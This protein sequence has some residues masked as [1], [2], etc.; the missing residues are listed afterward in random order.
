MVPTTEQRTSLLLAKKCIAE[1][2]SG[3][4]F[5]RNFGLSPDDAE[6]VVAD[7]ILRCL[8]A[9]SFRIESGKFRSYFL[10][11]VRS[12]IVENFRRSG[13]NREIPSSQL[14]DGLKGEGVGCH[15][16]VEQPLET[17]VVDFCQARA[18]V[19]QLPMINRQMVELA[20]EGYTYREIGRLIG[21]T[22]GS[23]RR[24]IH[25]SREFARSQLLQI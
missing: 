8:R 14:I 4:G 7:A 1:R 10:V 23:V 17:L 18:V 25:R 12:V 2:N 19:D 16:V 15:I 13:H 22:T 20:A 6:D 9:N 21:R 3:L 24:L 11:V 5:A